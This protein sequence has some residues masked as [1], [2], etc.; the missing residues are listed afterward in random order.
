MRSSKETIRFTSCFSARK[1][2][3][4][5]LISSVVVPTVFSAEYPLLA[6]VVSYSTSSGTS[7]PLHGCC[8]T[9]LAGCS[10]ASVVGTRRHF[11]LPFCRSPPP[12]R[13]TTKNG[14]RTD[15]PHIFCCF[16]VGFPFFLLVVVVVV[17]VD[18]EDPAG[19]QPAAP[20]QVSSS[21]LAS[22]TLKA[23]AALA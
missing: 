14:R 22:N 6:V 11:L 7:Q 23:T 19:S 1:V 2:A 4:D 5:A 12:P 15:E 21:R 17:V 3:V 18:N 13:G 10:F 20:N 8:Y 9:A 16:V